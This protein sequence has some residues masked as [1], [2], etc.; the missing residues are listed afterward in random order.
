MAH[1][2]VFKIFY[3]VFGHNDFSKTNIPIAELR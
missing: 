2:K 1:R 3:V